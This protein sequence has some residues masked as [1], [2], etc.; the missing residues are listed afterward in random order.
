MKNLTNID[1]KS[2]NRMAPSETARFLIGRTMRV[3]EVR[4]H[5]PFLRL[6]GSFRGFSGCLRL[7]AGPKQFQQVVRGTDQLPFRASFLD[8][9]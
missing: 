6:T 5:G 1:V 2:E 9:A 3:A 8:S 7:L 4:W